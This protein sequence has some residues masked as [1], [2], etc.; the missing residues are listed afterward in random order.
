MTGLG[1][2]CPLVLRL[3][4]YAFMLSERM[5][6]ALEIRASRMQPRRNML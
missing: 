2:F 5:L 6:Q 1:V 4:S 3:L